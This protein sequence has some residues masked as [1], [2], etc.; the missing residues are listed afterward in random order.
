MMQLTFSPRPGTPLYEQLYRAVVAQIRA[1]QLK[2]GERMPGKRSLA[3]QLAV[4]VNTVD[5]AY[6]MLAAE[7]WLEA[8]ERSGFFVLPYHPPLAPPAPAPAAPRASVLKTETKSDLRPSGPRA[9]R[10]LTNMAPS[11]T[12]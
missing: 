9:R 10:R 7:G 1:G 5:A 4:S 2:A 8:R 12:T 3:E 6:Q 11:M